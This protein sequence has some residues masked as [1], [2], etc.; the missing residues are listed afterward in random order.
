V[1]ILGIL[2]SPRNVG[3]TALLL[4]AVLKGAEQAGAQVERVNV[5]GMNMHC[6]VACGKCYATGNCVFEDDIEAVKA[7]M[8]A[9]DG[10]VLASPNYMLSVTA[11]LKTI[12]DRCSL[13]VHCFMLKDKYGAAVATAGGGME[14]EVAAYENMALQLCGAQTVGIATALGAGVG[15]LVDE[16]A[17]LAKATALGQDLVAAIGEKREYPEQADAHAQ[18]FPRMK[19]LVTAMAEKCAFQREYWAQKGWLSN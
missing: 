9:A 7:K 1:K 15:A 5:A 11:Q 6:C 10:I 8:L 18:F 4:D 2:G 19:H 3:N 16:E 13:F 12:M 17:A 14:D